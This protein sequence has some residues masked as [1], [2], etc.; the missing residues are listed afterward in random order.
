MRRQRKSKTEMGNSRD[1][2]R[3]E[4]E[5][6]AKRLKEKMQRKTSVKV[7]GAVPVCHSPAAAPLCL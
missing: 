7:R 6:E 2:K 5:R 1:E 4:G 3:R